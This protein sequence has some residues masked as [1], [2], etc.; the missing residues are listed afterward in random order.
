MPNNKK[1]VVIVTE[2]LNIFQILLKCVYLPKIKY[3]LYSVGSETL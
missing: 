1:N 3:Q 2:Y